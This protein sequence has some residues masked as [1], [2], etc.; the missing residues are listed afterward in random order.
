M[1]I[2]FLID[3]LSMPVILASV[4][5]AVLTIWDRLKNDRPRKVVFQRAPGWDTYVMH[6]MREKIEQDGELCRKARSLQLAE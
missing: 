3:A 4:S 2:N 1:T 6:Y 5:V